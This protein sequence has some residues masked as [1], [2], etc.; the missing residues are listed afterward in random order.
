VLLEQNC[1]DGRDN[2]KGTGYNI[3]FYFFLY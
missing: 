2:D 1:S 3:I